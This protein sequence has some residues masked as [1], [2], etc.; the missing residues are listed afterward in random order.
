MTLLHF[1]PSDVPSGT[2]RSMCV[3]S[4]DTALASA[5][6][7][8][9]PPRDYPATVVTPATNDKILPA[10]CPQAALSGS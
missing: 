3:H 2:P 8:L 10:A 4:A 5:L 7:C 9:F 1:R 6:E